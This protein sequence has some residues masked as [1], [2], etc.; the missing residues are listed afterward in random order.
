MMKSFRMLVALIALV[1]P[2][3]AS[4]AFASSGSWVSV[5]TQTSTTWNQVQE[6]NQQGSAR[7]GGQTV[8]ATDPRPRCRRICRRECE[9]FF[10][11]ICYGD[12][13][14]KTVVKFICNNFCEVLCDEIFP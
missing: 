2:S 4:M 1:L 8:S 7:W 11:E 9:T 13:A 6:T 5:S 3:L 12:G 10:D 14:C